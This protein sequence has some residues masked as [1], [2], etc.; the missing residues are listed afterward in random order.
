MECPGSRGGYGD[1]G[2]DMDI[3]LTSDPTAD[4]TLTFSSDA[5]CTL[6]ATTLTFT[7]SAGA[8]PWNVIQTITVTAVADTV[9]EGVH[10][11]VISYSAA[12]SDPNYAF[13]GINHSV[14]VIDSAP[15]LVPIDSRWMLCLLFGLLALIGFCAFTRRNG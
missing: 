7:N 8:N 1:A 15:V 14:T 6:S 4:V 3:V 12:S 13:T 5:Q 2:V 10:P 9:V 11:C